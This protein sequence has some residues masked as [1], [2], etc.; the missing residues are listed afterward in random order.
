MS[1]EIYYPQ[2]RCLNCSTFNPFHNK[3][4]N[5][6]GI[7]MV[8][9]TKFCGKCSSVLRKKLDKC[10]S[11][12][13]KLVTTEYVDDSNLEN[14]LKSEKDQFYNTIRDGFSAGNIS[15]DLEP[16]MQ[17]LGKSLRYLPTVQSF[18]EGKGNPSLIEEYKLEGKKTGEDVFA[19]IFNHFTNAITIG[20]PSGD[21]M[22]RMM[23]L[24][25]LGTAGK[26]LKLVPSLFALEM[27]VEEPQEI[28][29]EK[30][31]AESTEGPYNLD[32]TWNCKCNTCRKEW[33]AMQMSFDDG[34]IQSTDIT[35]NKDS[36]ACGST[37][38]EAK[39]V[40][41]SDSMKQIDAAF[42]KGMEERMHA[43][44]AAIIK[45]TMPDLD[46]IPSKEE[47]DKSMLEMMAMSMGESK[48]VLLVRSCIDYLHIILDISKIGIDHSKKMS[49]EDQLYEFPF[50]YDGNLRD[51]FIIYYSLLLASSEKARLKPELYE[52]L[53]KYLYLYGKGR[54][55]EN[56]VDYIMAS[57]ELHF[58]IIKENW[59]QHKYSKTNNA[60]QFIEDWLKSSSSFFKPENI[61]RFLT[62]HVK[63]IS[64]YLEDKEQITKNLIDPI[65]KSIN[66]VYLAMNIYKQNDDLTKEMLDEIV[67]I[68]SKCSQ[69]QRSSFF[70]MDGTMMIVYLSAYA[71]QDDLDKFN[72]FVTDEIEALKPTK[73]FC[74]TFVNLSKVGVTQFFKETKNLDIKNYMKEWSCK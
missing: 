34:E 67:K 17:L 48:I 52:E 23:S 21:M 18:I 36:C 24:L 73:K 61:F 55:S 4:C 31:E 59:N 72:K 74:K 3:F 20:F 12:K 37:N 70:T 51:E 19:E 1:E 5:N 57:I 40:K 56:Y 44:A 62:N 45:D 25:L 32:G 60:Y 33:Q 63:F 41:T 58:Q 26:N 27:G 29:T 16:V 54:R 64:E 35:G 6:C 11:C 68:Y 49:A 71:M 7:M 30:P 28:S 2:M 43:A 39:F 13:T 42:G 69:T 38:I 50:N 47:L 15:F 22:Q 65:I 8:D 46:N 53:G 14:I 66:L 10:K 9:D